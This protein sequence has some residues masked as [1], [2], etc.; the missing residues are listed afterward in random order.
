MGKY[1]AG[2][3][4]GEELAALYEDAKKNQFALPAINTTGSNT[5]NAVLE[6]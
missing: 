3:L 5:I 1:S 4:F 2:V 6:S